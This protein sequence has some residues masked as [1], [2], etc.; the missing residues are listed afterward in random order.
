MNPPPTPRPAHPVWDF[1]LRL[2]WSLEP[3]LN[4]IL[5]GTTDLAYFRMADQHARQ[6][7]GLQL[8]GDGLHATAGGQG[9]QV[10]GTEGIL[11]SFVPLTRM[12][13]CYLSPDGRPVYRLAALLDD[14]KSGKKAFF[15]LQN[16][17]VKVAG[18]RDVFLLQR[19]Y[20]T[21]TRELRQLPDRVKLLNQP[22]KEHPCEIE[23]L[24]PHELVMSFQ[25]VE[26]GCF[27]QAPRQ[28]DGRYHYELVGELKGALVDHVARN[29]IAADFHEIIRTIQDLR[30]LL[31]VNPRS[32]TSVG[33]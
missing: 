14:D 24:L 9:T 16:S 1:A 21:D 13:S 10:D 26:Q 25:E 33:R 18:W 3:G 2:G 6:S 20:P 22:W 28:V 7:L 32:G 12:A 19:A 30:F 11:D 29:A 23:D 17:R 15:D 31:N 5:E 27:R 8:L 4:L